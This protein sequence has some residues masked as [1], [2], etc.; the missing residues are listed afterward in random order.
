[1][2]LRSEYGAWWMWVDVRGHYHLC[3]M[4]MGL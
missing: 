4:P 2:N 1:M 3:V